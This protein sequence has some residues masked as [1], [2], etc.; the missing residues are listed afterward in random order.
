MQEQNN[1]VRYLQ[2]VKTSNQ[3]IVDK[4]QTIFF[5]EPY[6]SNSTNIV[7]ATQNRRFFL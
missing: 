4:I 2:I 3:Y 7:H 6:K 1:I 5:A